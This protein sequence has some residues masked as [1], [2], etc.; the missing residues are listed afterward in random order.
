M[1]LIDAYQRAEWIAWQEVVAATAAIGITEEDWTMRSGSVG[2]PGARTINA[3]RAWGDALVAL[4]L[5]QGREEDRAH[6]G[7]RI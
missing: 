1:G 3:I 4:R 2:T 7:E 5:F 6:R